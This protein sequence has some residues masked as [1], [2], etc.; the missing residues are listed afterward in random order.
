MARCRSGTRVTAL[1]PALVEYLW[2]PERWGAPT[3][4]TGMCTD[5]DSRKVREEWIREHG[6]DSLADKPAGNHPALAST[7]P[8]APWQS[9]H[10]ARMVSGWR[11]RA[12]DG[13][14]YTVD[15]MF[16]M[17]AAVVTVV[18]LTACTTVL[19]V[20]TPYQPTPSP[21]QATPRAPT[22][23]C[24]ASDFE[25]KFTLTCESAVAAAT[26]MLPPKHAPITDITFT[27]GGYCPDGFRCLAP[28]AEHYQTGYVVFYTASSSEPDLWVSVNVDPRDHEVLASGPAPF[29]PLVR[30][31]AEEPATSDG[32]TRRSLP[33]L[34]FS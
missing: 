1:S 5:L 28:P 22:V 7:R 20:P 30:A 29:P 31:Y 15:S 21:P 8:G 4:C 12:L 27:Y 2:P 25:I 17:L 11:H 24:D 18:V 26:A 32:T 3:Y 10:P 9:G 14:P 16:R 34:G 33:S 13:R 23:K 19:P 6:T